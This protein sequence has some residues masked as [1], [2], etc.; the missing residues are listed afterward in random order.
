[1]PNSENLTK[2]FGAL[3]NPHRLAI[4]RRLRNAALRCRAGTVSALGVCRIADGTELAL[5]TVSHHLKELKDAGLI[6]CEK[7]GQWVYCSINPIALRRVEAFVG[8]ARRR[9][10]RKRARTG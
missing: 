8:A 3:A 1:M 9:A 4:F 10:R 2:I 7:R 5:S 6:R